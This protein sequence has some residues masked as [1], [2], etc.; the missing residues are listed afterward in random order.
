M[1]KNSA[2]CEKFQ[3]KCV[4]GMRS[5][6]SQRRKNL[7]AKKVDYSSTFSH[8]ACEILSLTNQ[9]PNRPGKVAPLISG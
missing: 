6:S 7:S 2:K 1:R 5:D 4:T 9:N 3:A 8:F